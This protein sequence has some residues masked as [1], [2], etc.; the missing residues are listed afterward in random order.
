MHSSVKSILVH[1]K[2]W[3]FNEIPL[4]TFH[5]TSLVKLPI[6]V[7]FSPISTLG[8]SEPWGQMQILRSTCQPICWEP[9]G[10]RYSNLWHLLSLAFLYVTM[11]NTKLPQALHVKSVYGMC[12][13]LCE[14]IWVCVYMKDSYFIDTFE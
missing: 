13:E 6:M 9:E 5:L 2:H 14:Q 10:V 3:L 1:T 11:L 12:C 7:N 8:T 4:A